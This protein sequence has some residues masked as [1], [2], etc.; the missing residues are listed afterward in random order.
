MDKTADMGNLEDFEDSS[1][2]G[3]YSAATGTMSMVTTDK[4]LP[5]DVRV[6]V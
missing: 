3:V 1:G 4:C 6:Q 5:A 2:S